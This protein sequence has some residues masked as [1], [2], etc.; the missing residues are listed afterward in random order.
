MKVKT[1]A[2]NKKKWIL[3]TGF[4]ILLALAFQAGTAFG[5]GAEPGSSGDPLITRSYLEEELAD[6]KAGGFHKV[7]VPKGRT[8]KAASGTQIILYSGSAT[9]SKAGA[10]LNVTEGNLFS[11]GDTIAKYQSYLVPENGRGITCNKECILFIQGEYE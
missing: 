4:A 2:Q 3:G 8:V 11:A 1:F 5:A 7:K 9:V 10:L 6:L